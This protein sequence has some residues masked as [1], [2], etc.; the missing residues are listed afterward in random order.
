[1]YAYATSADTD[2]SDSGRRGSPPG[3][4]SGH[5]PGTDLTGNMPFA[6][7]SALGGGLVSRHSNLQHNATHPM[8]DFK[9]TA[10]V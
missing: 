9:E 10:D 8:P 7:T 6:G 1:M 4:G 5:G 2:V 3:A